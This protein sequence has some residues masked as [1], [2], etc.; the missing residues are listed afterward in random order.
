MTVAAVRLSTFSGSASV[1]LRVAVSVDTSPAGVVM[2]MVLETGA[3][4]PNRGSGPDVKLVTC[5]SGGVV[6]WVPSGATTVVDRSPL[7]A[8]LTRW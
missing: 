8:V 6:I 7:G 3:C 1:A 4:I 5:P 2:R